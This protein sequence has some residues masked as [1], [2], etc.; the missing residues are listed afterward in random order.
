[1]HVGMTTFFQNLTGQHTDR[2]V[3]QHE[4]SMADMAE[5][6]GFQSIWTAEHHFDDY[7]MCPN[8]LQFLTYMAGR[9]EHAGLG[10]MVMVLPWHDPV[11]VAEEIAVLDHVSDG[12]AII[13]VGRGL[14]RIEF[15]GFRV[16]MGESRERFIEYAEA[17][18]QGLETGEIEYDGKFYQQ[19][20]IRIKPAPF[21]SFNGRFYASAVS[22]ESSRIMARLGIGVMIIAQKPWDKTMAEL[23]AYREIYAE[24]H[25]GAAAPKP[26]L[27]SF[28]A[29]H[30]DEEVANDMH[31]QYIRRYS[32]SALDH[33]E[34]H[35]EG[36][37]DIKGYEYYGGL[38]KNI[39]KHGIDSFVD[40][41]ADL[42]VWGTPD[43][44]TE[45]LI[46]YQRMTDSAGLICAFSY[47]GMP[48]DMAK[49]NMRTF[50]EKVM[51]RIKNIS[52]DTTVMTNDTVDAA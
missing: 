38:S 45:R 17:V 2:E 3:Y 49:Q 52:V 1:M 43:Q 7:T 25:D 14:G 34:F 35:N 15:E 51:P 16:K 19:P 47:G 20:K 40:F 48:F 32:R 6:L 5:P 28:I 22:P 26:L 4:L 33:Y 13:G 36:L 27:V 24:M 10:S 18:L 23:N 21:K 12:R 8:P 42:Q 30:E 31:K 11:R 44:V 29:C 46:D 9:T 41:L 37:A 39:N 50:A